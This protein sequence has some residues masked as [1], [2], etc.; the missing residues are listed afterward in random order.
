[1][2]FFDTSPF[3]YSVPSCQSNLS[4][5]VEVDPAGGVVRLSKIFKWYRQDFGNKADLLGWLQTVLPQVFLMF[6]HF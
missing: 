3:T 1:M 5:D 2:P 6:K 4:G